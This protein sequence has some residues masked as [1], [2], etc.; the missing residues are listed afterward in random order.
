MTNET[1]HSTRSP[2]AFIS[3]AW[4][5]P[6]HESW[7]L[8]LS[9]RLREDG[10]DVILDKWDLKPGHDAH[11]FMEQMVRDPKVTKVIMVCDR[12]YTDKA[13]ERAGGVGIES[14]IISPELYASA[15]QDKYAAVIT[16]TDDDG[17]ALVPIFYTGRVY[18]DFANSDDYEP[19][20]DTLLRWILDKPLHV[21]PE[22]GEIPE[23]IAQPPTIASATASSLRR[24]E[25]AIK[26][27]SK[28]AGAL[29]RE[30]SGIFVC[31]L[32]EKG[33]LVSTDGVWEEQVFFSITR[34]RPYIAQFQ[35]VIRTTA[36]FSE[37]SDVFDE[38]L[39]GLESAGVLMF[40]PPGVSQWTEQSF[41][42]YRMPLWE[43]FLTMTAILIKER[44]FDLVLRAVKKAYLIPN[45]DETD[46]ATCD[47]TTFF[48]SNPTLRQRSLRLG[49][50][51]TSAEADLLLEHYKS[52]ELSIQDI[53]QAD[54]ILFL[55]SVGVST[56]YSRWYPMTLVF[57]QSHPP[58]ELFARAES[59]EYFVK[60]SALLGV[61]TVDEF[62]GV[63]T[64]IADRKE[65]PFRF[66]STNVFDVSNASNLGRVA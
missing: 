56:Q 60:I 54:F 16:E 59:Q 4:T 34:T 10:V 63:L 22:L 58:F 17:K 2:R 19:A 36:R 28:T 65:L 6:T 5:S 43:L 44:R 62:K 49:F 13:N 39:N 52:G 30:F 9:T 35:N 1:P 31:E 14:Q 32:K 64:G 61:S 23:H 25:E 45:K 66:W 21:K 27:G 57:A 40:R 33:A 42:N 3:Y 7:V 48:H 18:V 46:R 37:G 15:A 51:R 11:V 41:D 12:N 8:Q 26:H 47:Y 53:M 38:L 29:V 55:R 20:Y 24:A 50:D